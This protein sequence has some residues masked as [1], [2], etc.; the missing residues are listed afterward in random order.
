MPEG[1]PQVVQHEAQ[2]R[3]PEEASPGFVMYVDTENYE[4]IEENGT[5]YVRPVPIEY[6]REEIRKQQAALLEDLSQEEQEAAIDARIQELKEFYASLPANEIEI[7]EVPEKE[8]STYAEE[9]RNQMSVNWDITE[10]IIWVDKP[11][12]YTFSISCGNA[13]DSPYEVHYFVDNGEHGTFHIIARYRVEAAE[14]HGA[15]F[16]SMIQTY[17]SVFS[18]VTTSNVWIMDANRMPRPSAASR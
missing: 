4:M 13:W 8:F 6:D 2:G 17:W 18:L 10:D 7:Y 12:A 9:V 1:T 11:L 3:D 14:G 5:F 16:T 15:R